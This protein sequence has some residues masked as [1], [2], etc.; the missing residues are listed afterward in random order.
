MN[1]IYC[2][3]TYSSKCS[4]KTH[5]YNNTCKADIL[6][7]KLKLYHLAL[8]YIDKKYIIQNTCIFCNKKY[9]TKY[10]FE[11]HL[12]TNAC[13]AFCFNNQYDLYIYITS[14]NKKVNNIKIAAPVKQVIEK[15]DRTEYLK[16]WKEQN[17][18]K[19]QLYR[20]KYQQKIKNFIEQNNHH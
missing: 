1:C 8:N 3:K 14:F 16:Q 2:Y 5:L 10:T 20:E 15:K 6:T 13:K 17:K 7:C 4:L 18:D 9:S 12:S 19:V 11:R